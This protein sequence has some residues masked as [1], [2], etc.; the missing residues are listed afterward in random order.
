VCQWGERKAPRHPQLEDP[1]GGT[2]AGTSRALGSKKA[3]RA[4]KILTSE[5]TYSSSFSSLTTPAEVGAFVLWLILLEAS[6]SASP[7]PA[8]FALF[9]STT[10]VE[11]DRPPREEEEVDVDDDVVAPPPVAAAAALLLRFKDTD[12]GIILSAE[13]LGAAVEDGVEVAAAA[14]P[15]TRGAGIRKPP[16]PNPAT[17]LGFCLDP[18]RCSNK[19][20]APASPFALGISPKKL[21]FEVSDQSKVNG[22]MDKARTYHKGPF[23]VL[24]QPYSYS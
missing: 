22:W 13:E 20:L 23:L 2:S 8:V 5:G 14:F 12:G 3:K 4:F 16:P 19:S 21:F 15:L 7:P 17:D 6:P 10:V 18:S 1:A 9:T 24:S 11:E